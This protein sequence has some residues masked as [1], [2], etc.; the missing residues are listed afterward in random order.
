MT[1]RRLLNC[2][3]ALAALAAPAPGAFAHHAF[4]AEFDTQAKLTLK[5]KVSAVELVNPHS[6]ITLTVAEPGK[7]PQA[8]RVLTATPSLL[9]H[10]GVCKASMPIGTEVSISVYLGKDKSCLTG[11]SGGPHPVCLVAGNFLTFPATGSFVDIYSSGAFSVYSP[12][13]TL[14][15]TSPGD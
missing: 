14:C 11:P 1:L 4:E 6:I 12:E 15:R 2:A 13:E 8:W 3:F 10:R 9:R 5:G 7:A